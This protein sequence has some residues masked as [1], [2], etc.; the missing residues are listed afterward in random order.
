MA[1][2]D[3]AEINGQLDTLIQLVAVALTENKKDQKEQIRILTLAGLPPVRIANILGT[4]GNSV[5]GT[6]TKLRREKQLPS[7]KDQ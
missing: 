1:R 6:I 4:S 7:R 2:I 3:Q 5:N